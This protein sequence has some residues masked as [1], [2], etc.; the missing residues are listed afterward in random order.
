MNKMIIITITILIGIIII[1]NII[2]NFLVHKNV[3]NYDAMMRN[4]SSTDC[5]HEC[6][7]GVN[8]SAF[9]YKPGDKKCF[10]SR[11]IILGK[12]KNGLYVDQ[13]SPLDTRCNK[14]NRLTDSKQIDVRTLTENSVYV[15]ADGEKN[16]YGEHQYANRGASA[17]DNNIPPTEVKYPVRMIEWPKTIETEL[18]PS[19]IKPEK[20]KIKKENIRFVESDDEFLGQYLLAHQCV[21]D[22]PLYD[23]IKFCNNNKDCAGVEWLEEIYDDLGENVNFYRTRNSICCPKKII[24][25]IIPRRSKYKKGKFYIKTKTEKSDDSDNMTI[26]K[27]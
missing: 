8:C 17:L 5:G 23:C 19:F 25:K 22:I 26:S 16:I 3:E 7:I 27:K 24:S 15:C 1:V 21:A 13:Y 10:L 4:I 9:A 18:I 12:P 11:E 14:I 20:E 2:D 6:T